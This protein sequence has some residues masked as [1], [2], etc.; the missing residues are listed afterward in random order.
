MIRPAP[1]NPKGVDK[2]YS[3]CKQPNQQREK[4]GQCQTWDQNSKHTQ[5]KINDVFTMLV[6]IFYM[7][8]FE[9]PDHH[10]RKK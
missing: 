2:N 8:L 1:A 4:E 5:L 6:D 10:C 9:K 7:I 3:T